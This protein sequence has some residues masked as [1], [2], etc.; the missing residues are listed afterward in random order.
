[1][2][3]RRDVT[4]VK[5]FGL[6]RVNRLVVRPGRELIV[7]NQRDIGSPGSEIVRLFVSFDLLGDDGNLVGTAD[8]PARDQHIVPTV[9]THDS[10]IIRC[11]AVENSV[12]AEIDVEVIGVKLFVEERMDERR[13]MIH[14]RCTQDICEIISAVTD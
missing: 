5:F 2:K 1:M 8:R 3:D 14:H 11:I 10:G 12:A 6:D 13:D 9:E 7:G 4:A